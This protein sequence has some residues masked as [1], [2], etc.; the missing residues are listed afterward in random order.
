[1]NNNQKT[2][3]STP[4]GIRVWLSAIIFGLV[5]QIAW[6]V[7]NMYFATF[8]QDIF[9]NI[10]RH[11]LGYIVTT[12]MVILS[13]LT[14]T[15]TTI[16]A[17]GLCDKVG[18][19]KPFIAFGY[20]VWGFTIMIFSFIPMRPTGSMILGSAVLLILFDCIMTLAGSTS[21][22]TAFNAYIADVS[23]ETNRGKLNAILSVLPVFAVVIV[24]VGLGG[25]YNSQ[26]QSNFLFF[27]VLGA[28]PIVA[29]IL[30]IFT[31]KDSPNIQKTTGDNYLKDTFYGFSK[32]VVKQNK[33]LYITLIAYC[34]V[35]VSQQTFFS[36]LINFVQVTLGYGDGFILPMAI[37][38]V[39]SAVLTGVVG[40]FFDKV[41]RK[42]FYFPLLIGVILGCLSF[43]LTKF[44]EKGIGKDLLVYFG[45]IIMMGSI[46]SLT[47]ALN[48]TFQDNIP[49]GCEGRFQGVRMCFTVLIPMIIGPIVSLIIGLDAMGIND[50]QGF[51][52]PHA[53]FLAASIIAL[54]GFI[55]LY[56]VRKSS[57]ETVRKV[58]QNEETSK[59]DLA[60]QE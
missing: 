5:G 51:T 15:I 43:Y 42:H 52:P 16:F 31:L 26:N 33:L 60:E 1:M 39:G 58:E 57:K 34:I 28:I 56:F 19:R 35:A 53:I 41:G 14:A 30:A 29:G 9:A 55:P 12:L 54:L 24:F 32:T 6:V 4:L 50:A 27:V 20:I 11:D 8:A 7:E 46:L 10:D 23:D 48:S 13:A 22:D 36:Y 40:I 18:K 3:K 59:K 25:L 38:I 44:I 21:N 37:V 2:S 17:G 47:G 45:G 49:S